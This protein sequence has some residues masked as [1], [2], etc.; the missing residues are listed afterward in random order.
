MPF[1]PSLVELS[2]QVLLTNVN[3]LSSDAVAALPEHVQL[4][5]FDGVLGRGKLNEHQA[6]TTETTR[7]SNTVARGEPIV[8]LS[9]TTESEAGARSFTC[10]D[11]TGDDGVWRLATTDERERVTRKGMLNVRG[12][13]TLSLFFFFLHSTVL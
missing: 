9:H 12:E 7:D 6:A 11:G 5:L 2:F 4:G 1:V 8:V 13:E 10:N 3:K